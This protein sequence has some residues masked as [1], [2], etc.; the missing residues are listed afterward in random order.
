MKA[1][2]NQL[3]EELHNLNVNL[4]ILSDIQAENGKKLDIIEMQL[5]SIKWAIQ[6]L[7]Q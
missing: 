7:K 1:F 2:E 3:I 4:D 5:A 6:D